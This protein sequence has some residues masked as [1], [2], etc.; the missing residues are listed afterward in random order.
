MLRHIRI[1][2]GLNPAK[3]QQ[4]HSLRPARNHH[5]V[6]ARP[7]AQIG[8]RNRLQ[9]RRAKPVDGNPGNLYRQTRPQSRPACNIPSL[10]ALRLRAAKNHVVDFVPA[11]LWNPI[12][13][14]TQCKCGQIVG[15]RRRKRAFRSAPNG[16]A[17]SADDHSFRHK[18][19]LED[20]WCD[21]VL[22]GHGFSRADRQREKSWALAPKG[23]P[24]SMKRNQSGIST[25]VQT[26]L[27]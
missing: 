10:L 6:A 13:S 15:P 1:G 26:L 25:S 11:Q 23:M 2:A 12:Q 7:N 22:K 4:A 19:L 9:S 27:A 18:M 21:L 17:N 16:S 8:Q 3:G 20:Q 24:L 14:R 5:P